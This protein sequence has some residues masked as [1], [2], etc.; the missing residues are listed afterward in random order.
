M[1]VAGLY[2]LPNIFEGELKGIFDDKRRMVEI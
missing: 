1:I 2:L